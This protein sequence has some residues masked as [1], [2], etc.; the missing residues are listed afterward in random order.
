MRNTT[1][2]LKK[3]VIASATALTLMAG[4]ALMSGTLTDHLIAAGM[5]PQ[6]YAAEGSGKGPQGGGGGGQQGG[7]AHG[8]GDYGGKKGMDRVLDAGDDSDSDRPVWAGQPG[9][10]GRPGGGGNPS[11]GVVKG[12]EY[13]DL[14]VLQRDPVTGVPIVDE[15]G[16]YLVCLDV[17]C[18][19]T[20]PTVD[21][22]VPEGVSAVEVDFG[23]AAVAR[24]PDTV[25]EK[26]L[27]DALTK[28][29]ADGVVIST[30]TA[31][32]IT[33]TVDGVTTSIDSPLENLALY[34]DLMKGLASDSTSQTEAALGDLATLNTAA[35]LLAGVADKT[36]D[37]SIDYVFYQNLIT[38]VVTNPDT[39]FD[40][41]GFTYDRTFDKTTYYVS[42]E[43][44]DPV[45]K[46]IDLDAY[47]EAV[48]GALPPD[49]DYAALF[50]AAAD[51]ALEVIEF[52][53]T[54]VY[55]EVLPG[56]VE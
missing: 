5:F 3:T 46:T 16:E 49:G 28:L 17:A 32:R 4:P 38:D 40:Y 51:D 25:A 21:G 1:F 45:L 14:I 50:A 12:D 19:S 24:A 34:I 30:D 37:I 18:T 27:D 20:V 15:N 47:L 29:T 44:A 36:G 39:Y 11:P 10:E 35:A 13:G 22:E 55:N 6:A 2:N 43:G 56:T 42:I 26:A 33:Y 53:H 54:Q 7:Q 9:G 31:G 23:R 48:N 41:S 8:A 52:V